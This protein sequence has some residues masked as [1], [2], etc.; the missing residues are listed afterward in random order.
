MILTFEQLKHLEAVGED[1]YKFIGKDKATDE[2]IKELVE[3]DE[4]YVDVYGKHMI[5]N[6]EELK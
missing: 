2:E 1:T 4:S 5:T 6:H 3:L